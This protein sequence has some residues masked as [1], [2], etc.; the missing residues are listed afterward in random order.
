MNDVV[1][2]SDDV[3]TTSVTTTLSQE[4]RWPIVYALFTCWI[5]PA[6][7]ARRTAHVPLW[8]VWF[9]HFCSALLILFTILMLVAY[10]EAKS[11]N[12]VSIVDRLN[13][14]FFGLHRVF[15]H[16]PLN[17]IAT[18]FFS[19][20][21]IQ[22]VFIIIPFFLMA[23]GAKDESLKSSY[24]N[25]L[26]QLWI[27]TAHILLILIIVA[28]VGVAFENASSQWNRDHPSPSWPIPPAPPTLSQ[29]DPNYTKVNS[30]Y[31]VA[32]NTYDTD[33]T[34]YQSKRR[35]INNLRPWYFG[36]YGFIVAIPSFVM[37]LWM[38]W[39]LLRGIGVTRKVPKIDRPPLCE[40]CGYNLTSMPLDSRC[41]ECG[42]YVIDSLG[43][44]ARTGTLWEKQYQSNWRLAWSQ[45]FLLP[46]R[47][48]QPF[49]RKIQITPSTT[50]HRYYFA[51]QLPMIFFIGTISLFL[52]FICT[53]D[54]D[55]VNDEKYI[56]LSAA[57]IFGF[58]CVI[59]T[60]V[61]T[62]FA[63][64]LI[65]WAQSLRHKRNL[66]PASMQ[67]SCYLTGYLVLWAIFG[68]L[69]AGF[70]FLMHELRVIHELNY[71]TGMYRD[72]IITLMIFVPNVI[73]G[74]YYLLLVA[75]V[76]SGAW[77]ANR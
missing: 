10:S 1:I 2:Q 16:K 31:L 12:L 70:I 40:A 76:T 37:G 8:Q 33:L 66:M 57:V 32:K 59:G 22:L 52:S 56:M 46:I 35:T 20:L 71:L 9:F 50:A 27:R 48:S 41:P 15:Q 60:V 54:L 7:T 58:A 77:Y 5:Y 6:T 14:I 53:A 65:G 39:A 11:I 43:P 28:P 55:V 25:A 51:M 38:I 68:A 30:E 63:G 23:W 69:N 47:S 29:N 61:V 13:V 75:R 64:W 74:V 26:R 62:L 72:S 36:F 3:N 49:G 34:I 44:G 19:F 24:R 18:V 67:A 21:G 4:P 42:E 17:V 73:C 45:S